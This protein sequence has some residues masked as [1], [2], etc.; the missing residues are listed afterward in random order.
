M[1]TAEIF[2]NGKI[3]VTG[4]TVS[5]SVKHE[6]IK[7]IFPDSWKSYTKTAVFSCGDT[8]INLLLDVSNALCIDEDTC[9]IPHEVIKYPAFTVSVYGVL[10]DKRATAEECE[11]R[12]TKS[13]FLEGDEPS[14]PTPSEYSQ[15][16]GIMEEAKQIAN[17]V[18]S[19]A[20]NGA[21]KGE[22]GDKGDTGETGPKGD[23]G[24]KG[25]IGPSGQKGEKGEKGDTG[26]AGSDYILTEADKAEIAQIAKPATDQ[27]YNPKS[28]NAQ[29]GVAVEEAIKNKADALI[30]TTR[31]AKTHTITDSSEAEINALTLFG[32]YAFKGGKNLICFEE[33]KEDSYTQN[34]LTFTRQT[35]GSFLVNGT[36]GADGIDMFF[37]TNNEVTF[38]TDTYYT[39]SG[40]GNLFDWWSI[41]TNSPVG[42]GLGTG[43]FS[44]GQ[45]FF[46]SDYPGENGELVL[47]DEFKT[48]STLRGNIE[49]GKV[50]NNVRFAPQIEEGR[51]ATAFE[52]PFSNAENP[53]I[54]VTGQNEG[55]KAQ[56]VILP[57]TFSNGDTLTVKE[58][59]V[60]TNIGGVKTDI[61]ETKE[62]QAL[63]ALQTNYPVTNIVCD[64]DLEV[65]Y[66]ADTTNAYNN[67]LGR[68]S[69]LEK[70]C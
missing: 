30:L 7:F 65:S 31:R 21:F 17:S 40:F 25:E 63:M 14:K 45:I 3:A 62:G 32:D 43:F 54:R 10:A 38:K 29:S 56:E 48:T 58:G 53:V 51:V 23:K 57:Y 12:V 60:K 39:L 36:A 13:G 35:D 11:V 41:D 1:L 47:F 49:V 42:Y 50:F 26:E 46:Y 2:E 67:L 19:D 55:D 20:D 64:A 44:D 37:L 22:K 18:R 27:N 8:V 70:N 24:D 68:I 69:A 15:M 6:G 61:S 4:S 9:Y 16:I 28:Q 52:N 59:T 34:G 5:D 33:L 66:L